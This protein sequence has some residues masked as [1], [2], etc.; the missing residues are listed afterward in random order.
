MG[1]LAFGE[2][3]EWDRLTLG[4]VEWVNWRFFFLG[5]ERCFVTPVPVPR[6]NILRSVTLDKIL[7]F[8]KYWSGVPFLGLSAYS[9]CACLGSSLTT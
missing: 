5:R 7:E 2:L 6:F 8:W 4:F 3:F 1:A 9:K